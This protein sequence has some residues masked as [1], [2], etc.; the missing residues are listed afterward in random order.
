M[1]TKAATSLSTQSSPLAI[2]EKVNPIDFCKTFALPAARMCGAKTE[3]DGMAIALVCLQ[4]GITFVEFGRRYHMIMGRPSM[5][6]D[7]MLAEFRSN[8]GGDYEIISRTADTAA[9]RFIDKKGRT[10]DCEFTWQQAQESRWPWNDWTDH[11][12]GLKD[13]WSTPTDR[14]SMLFVRL[15]SDSLRAICPELVAGIYTP[16]EVSDFIDAPF[17]APARAVTTDTIPVATVD[18]V[19]SVSDSPALAGK[20]VLEDGEIID[21]EYSVDTPSLSS[22]KAEKIGQLVMTAG[23]NA[24][25]YAAMLGRRGVKEVEELT[26]EQ[27]DEIISRLEEVIAA[28]K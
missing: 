10:Y 19:S 21:A 8:Y 2:A 1:S 23:M 6:S 17:T 18:A 27:A 9:I 26:E 24:E 22:R 12:K 13:A 16:E 4:E 25:K 3:Q 28:K 7:A 15:V 11:S 14:K 5:R 20:V